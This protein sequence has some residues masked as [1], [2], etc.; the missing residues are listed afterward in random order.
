[1]KIGDLV[2]R[3]GLSE[4]M[5]RH[6]EALGILAPAR[7]PGGTR[8][9]SETD[10][11][12][13]RLAQVFRAVDV[14]LDVAAAIA[15]ERRKHPTGDSSQRA[16]GELLDGLADDLEARAERSLALRRVVSDAASAVR[17]CAGCANRPG[18]TTC[19]DCPMNHAAETNAVAAMIWQGD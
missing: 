14:P 12:I 16:I 6:Y 1:M 4:R 2:R 8:D 7:S 13:A 11:E 10:V 5:L 17:A 9:Y 15:A 3:T 19:P 18:A